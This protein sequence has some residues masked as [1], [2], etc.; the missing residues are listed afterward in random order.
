MAFLEADLDNFKVINDRYGHHVGDRY[1]TEISRVLKS[2]LRER[3][4][5]VR[6]SG[7]EFAAI[8]P[9]T[10]FAQAALLSERLQQ[11]VDLF[12]LRLEEGNVARSGLSIGIALYPQDGEGFE[13]LLVRADHNMYQNK[14]ARKNARLELAPNIVPFP[15]KKPTGT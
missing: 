8:L 3:D 10:G 1:L 14:A 12:T 2:H 6:L 11:A 4:I 13:D 7:D 9:L 15:I 5:L